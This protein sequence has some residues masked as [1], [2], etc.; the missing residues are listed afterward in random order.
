[1]PTWVAPYGAI[2]DGSRVWG[3]SGRTVLSKARTHRIRQAGT[4]VQARLYAAGPCT[5]FRLQVWRRVGVNSYDRVGQS[6]NVGAALVDGLNTLTLATPIPGVQ[7][8]DY[9]GYVMDC[10]ASW[11]PAPAASDGQSYYS[12]V[13]PGATGYAW[14]S[15]STYAGV[16]PIEVSVEEAPLFVIIGDSIAVGFPLHYG[17]TSGNETHPFDPSV[18]IA[19]ALS[20]TW[21]GTTQNLGTG[22][23]TSSQIAARIARDV[24]GLAPCAAILE[25]GVNDIGTGGDLETFRA[26]WATILDA[27]TAAGIIPI[28]LKIL[29]WT[30]GSNT[31]LQQ[32][33]NWNA[34]LVEI[35]HRYPTAIL[36]D[37]SSA[38]GQFRVGGDAGNLWDIQPAYTM[39]GAHYTAAANAVIAAAIAQAVGEAL[40]MSTTITGTLQDSL[41]NASAGRLL[42]ALTQAACA[43][44]ELRLPSTALEVPATGAVS[45][46]LMANALLLPDGTTYAFRVQDAG[47]AERETASGVTVT[48][49]MDTLDDIL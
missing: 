35:V 24:V 10:G 9:L 34:H 16:V 15:Q 1:M 25:G 2:S 49:V 14:E 29:P 21:G 28:V 18:S 33:D 6:E 13:A 40:T 46:S 30:N 43:E 8:G 37:L 11:F 31:Q 44:D 27:V 45:L 3:G 39:D 36:V 17:T 41:G 26:N 22:S 47:G 5:E 20:A 19:Y 42:T 48:T 23:Q 7:E 4:I 38:V 32:R 12:D